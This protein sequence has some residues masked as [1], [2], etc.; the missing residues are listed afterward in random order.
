[1]YNIFNHLINQSINQSYHPAD[2]VV[3]QVDHVAEVS[4]LL[5]DVHELPGELV[6]EPSVV[7]ASAPF[8]VLSRRP[9]VNAVVTGTGAHAAL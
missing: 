7:R 4:P 5:E 9:L 6:S 2:F 3:V 1:M 8:P